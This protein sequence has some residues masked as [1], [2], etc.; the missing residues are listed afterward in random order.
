MTDANRIAAEASFACAALLEQGRKLQTLS[1]IVPGIALLMTIT[2]PPL[3]VERRFLVTAVVA[4]GL[5][6]LYFAV[7]VGLDRRLMQRFAAQ[8][9][10]GRLDLAALDAG[11][12]L[13][14]LRPAAASTRSLDDRIGGA[15][16][17][18]RNQAIAT[19]A[20]LLVLTGD[21]FWL[22]ASP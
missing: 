9:D 11:L 4:L 17:L 1:L 12:T 3:R 6:A 7:R 10:A 13:A 21:V 16:R 20:Q 2:P 15:K 5:A 18:L 19:A 22:S 8:A 14:G